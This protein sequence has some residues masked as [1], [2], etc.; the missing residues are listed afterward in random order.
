MPQ[1]LFVGGGLPQPDFSPCPLPPVQICQSHTCFCDDFSAFASFSPA[2]ALWP[3]P[4]QTA[5]QQT[6]LADWSPASSPLP[7]RSMLK[8]YIITQPLWIYHLINQFEMIYTHWLTS[9]V[10]QNFC[11]VHQFPNGTISARSAPLLVVSARSYAGAHR[12]EYPGMSGLLLVRCQW[13][14]HVSLSVLKR[15]S[16]IISWIYKHTE[17]TMQ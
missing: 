5:P 13:S 8:R 4:P 1:T 10:P 2:S 9:C 12:G 16:N 11:V 15:K 14:W 7:S 3:S 6:A 17:R